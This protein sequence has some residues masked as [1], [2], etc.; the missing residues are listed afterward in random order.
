MGDI[1]AHKGSKHKNG[2]FGGLY[3]VAELHGLQDGPTNI[4]TL[5]QEAVWY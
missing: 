4:V 5:R 1:E 3:R 2:G